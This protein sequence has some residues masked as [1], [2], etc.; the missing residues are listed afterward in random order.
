MSIATLP[1]PVTI[2]YAGKSVQTV[3]APVVEF[4]GNVA[5]EIPDLIS[6]IRRA[7]RQLR[8]KDKSLRDD[9]IQEGLIAVLRCA[10]NH[11]I[12]DFLDLAYWRMKDYLKRE[13]IRR[14][15]P[16]DSQGSPLHEKR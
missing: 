13:K 15:E 16:L 14:H 5:V 1:S 10:K 4:S 11:T 8:P 6:R 12:P 2:H 7:A 3:L 9:L